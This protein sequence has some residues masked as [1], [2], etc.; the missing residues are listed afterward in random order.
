M[1][2]ILAHC[3]CL[4]L[5]LSV[6][7]QTPTPRPQPTP[8]PQ[9]APQQPA[10]DEE[11]LRVTTALVQVDAVVV[12]KNDR[13]VPDLK[14][15]DF[16][17]YENGKKQNLQ[18]MEFIDTDAG[19]GAGA[20][21]VEGNR[22]LAKVAPGAETTVARELS[23]KDVKRVFAF[24]V[25]DLTIPLEDMITVR[26][27]LTDFVNNQ[28]RDGD[29]VAIVRSVGGKGL[30]QQFTTDKQLLRRAIAQLTVTTNPLSTFNNPPAGRFT[31]AP[32]MVSAAPGSSGDTVSV[33]SEAD[34]T[35]EDF[36]TQNFGD[37][38]DE[39]V[40]LLRGL[41]SLST[42]KYVV[43]SMKD[44][45][46]RKSMVLITGG[47]PIF[48]IAGSGASYSNVTYML[49]QLT[50]DAVRSGVAISTM[51]PRGLKASPGVAKFTDTPAR[52]ALGGAA[53]PNFGRG[54][55][56][57]GRADITP[58]G[59]LNS[60]GSDDPFG[61]LL[62]GGAEHLGLNTL[63]DA[64]GGVSVVNTN[65]FHTGLEKVMAHSSGYYLLAYAPTEKFDNKFRRFQIK[66]KRPGLTVYT[67]RG[68]LARSD[69]AGATP[70]REE[71]IMTAAKSPLA[72]RDL[73]VTANVIL[74]P[75][76]TGGKSPIDVH[77][78]I[79]P[80]KLT[81]T[82]TESGRYQASFDVV[83]FVY[84]QLGKLRGGF[85]ET[86]KTDLTQE[87]YKTAMATGLTYSASTELPPGYYQ[88][89]G[90][91]R[92][93]GTGNLGTISK[94]LEVPDI[95]NGRLAMSS[96]YLFAADP[97]QGPK[98]APVPLLA[99]R[100]LTRK[101]D[102]RYAALIYNAKNSGGRSEL[103]AQVIISQGGNILYREP[104]Q[105]VAVTG[106][107]PATKIGQVAL[108]GVPPG[109]YVLTLIVTDPLAD[110]KSQIVARS[111]DFSVVK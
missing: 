34:T 51:D 87:N 52:S 64:T 45:P 79:D 97:A 57:A 15:S 76:P 22:D 71:S 100:Q 55:S 92:E 88:L 18:F 63:A 68:Y 106:T 72:R 49:N 35:F 59:D 41:V 8:P 83:G 80:K 109:R 31:S 7:A 16:E 24:V 67:H 77:L 26:Q 30:L 73:D 36:G 98:A 78:L 44:I 96:L 13:P 60:A 75:S 69:R 11:I 107:A 66:V 33:G 29:L 4:L 10:Q 70:T 81:F 42:A 1:K 86:V 14:M 61:P 19:T 108:S 104:E 101:Q 95:S 56:S 74:K 27:L 94:Y 12:D 5:T 28:M 25:D 17:V 90:A 93:T 32:Q 48:E 85:S 91:V 62:A 102:L 103:R 110:K 3:L 20:S 46:G 2:K 111:I 40:R 82:Q 23:A 99:V 9:P 105:P 65:N 54:G 84:D 39:T 58:S 89:R 53:D 50:D 6:A 37:P 43:E 21:R 38:N 47:I